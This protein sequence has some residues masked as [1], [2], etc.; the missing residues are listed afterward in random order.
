MSD[1]GLTDRMTTQATVARR[2]QQSATKVVRRSAG[3]VAAALAV[4]AGMIFA[5]G[6]AAAA[7]LGGV[8]YDEANRYCNERFGSAGAYNARPTDA[9][10]AYS[11]G[12]FYV[13]INWSSGVD[14]NRACTIKYG[15]PAYSYSNNPRWAWVK[16]RD[17]VYGVVV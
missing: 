2:G 7:V 12:C 16:S 11:W 17:V 4:C 10:N 8:G 1:L 9:F 13:N 6:T 3:A 5:P 14:F 15:S